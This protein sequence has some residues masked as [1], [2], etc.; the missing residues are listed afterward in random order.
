MDERSARRNRETGCQFGPFEVFQ[1][2]SVGSARI[3]I[4][5]RSI[6]APHHA[7]Q[8]TAASGT[9]GKPSAPQ[10]FRQKTTGSG[11]RQRRT[12]ER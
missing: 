10:R 7:L 6:N 9:T 3:P 2:V 11:L 4:L 12:R 5:A 8:R 1:L